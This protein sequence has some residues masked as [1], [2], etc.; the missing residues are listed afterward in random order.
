[1][2]LGRM[3]LNS[4]TVKGVG[5]ADL[6]RLSKDRDIPAIAPWRD[7]IADVGLSHAARMI[8]S[9]GLRVSSLC[10]GGMFTHE[11]NGDGQRSMQDNRRA[12][13]EAYEIGAECL[14]LV[15]GPVTHRSPRGSLDII[16]DAVG[17]LS[18]YALRAGVRLAIEPLHPML[19]ANRS[20]LCT[21][22]QATDILASI[23]SPVT[24]ICIDVYHVWW[25]PEAIEAI[26]DLADAIFGFH[27]SDWTLPING[28]L[29]SRGMMG[30]GCIDLRGWADA[31]YGAG[32]G[33]FAEVE[34]LSAH[35]WSMPPEVVVD[36]AVERFLAI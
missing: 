24:G 35:W 28:E 26:P 29:E 8:R 34:V 20:A 1:M 31:V 17:E 33:G 25:D 23:D 2:D 15:C 7:L 19:A 32:Y 27:V 3:S 22:R 30:D 6:I 10:R 9:S 12:V 4:M 18:E 36:T 14:V 11:A 5:L 21:V 16:R 13:D